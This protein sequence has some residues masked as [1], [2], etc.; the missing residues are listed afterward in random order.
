MSMQNADAMINK[1]NKD[2]TKDK[3][4]IKRHM[5][6]VEIRGKE[7]K[8]LI[9]SGSDVNV[10]SMDVYQQIGSPEC[11]DDNKIYTGL[12]SQVKSV[13]QCL[14]SVMVNGQEYKDV[15]FVIMDTK[16]VPHSMILGNP[17]LKNVT[18]VLNDGKVM[19]L[20][21]N[22]D[23]W[24]NLLCVISDETIPANIGYQVDKELKQRVEK[25]VK[26]YEPRKTKEA[27]VDLHLKDRIPVAQRPRRLAFKEQQEVEKQVKQWL[28]DGIVQLGVKPR[29]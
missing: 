9:D 6:M 20:P 13:G 12:G 3:E 11:F 21:I 5:T 4:D 17:F 26:S 23:W 28:D 19:L 8:A 29:Q 25:L 15:S 24:A 27:N 16:D 10:I 2:E 7:V 22:E 14:L 18:C 1:T